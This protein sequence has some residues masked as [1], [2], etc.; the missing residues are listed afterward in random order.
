M[1]SGTPELTESPGGA[2]TGS[3]EVEAVFAAAPMSFT[4]HAVAAAPSDLGEGAAAAAGIATPAACGHAHPPGTRCVT[5]GHTG[6]RGRVCGEPLGR[7]RFAGGDR[8]ALNDMGVGLTILAFLG[9][10]TRHARTLRRVC[11][12]FRAA[13]AAFP[14]DDASTRISMTVAGWSASVPRAQAANVSERQDLTV[15]DFA[16]HLRGVR[17]L[18]VSGCGQA[19][20]ADGS[21]VGA[22][23][24][25]PEAIA[26]L[27]EAAR[28]TG[29]ARAA[30]SAAVD[31][32]GCVPETSLTPR[33][34]TAEV[35]ATA[36]ETDLSRAVETCI[37][38]GCCLLAHLDLAYVP[39]LFSPLTARAP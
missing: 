27:R 24:V 3:V 17:V 12:D 30:S 21:F 8:A 14:W 34:R 15:Q 33:H 23:P 2:S 10:D 4:D 25:P 6:H 7:A 16:V 13:V 29:A 38:G 11:K 37:K 9:Y 18:N 1:G 39:P 26:K 20:V 36:H 5:C 28:A 32:R 35:L 31:V 22:S 19:C